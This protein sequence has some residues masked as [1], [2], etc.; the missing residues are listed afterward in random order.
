M[1]HLE[2]CPQHNYLTTCVFIYDF[3]LLFSYQSF[4]ELPKSFDCG[5]EKRGSCSTASGTRMLPENEE[6][7]R[8]SQNMYVQESLPQ[9]LACSKVIYVLILSV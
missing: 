6:K 3:L 5:Q 9:R 8:H 7:K 1:V 2:K 4:K